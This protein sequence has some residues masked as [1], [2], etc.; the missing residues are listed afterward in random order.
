MC[1][2]TQRSM[3]QREPKR[4]IDP[5]APGPARRPAGSAAPRRRSSN[6]R[7]TI[8]SLIGREIRR[9][10]AI[11]SLRPPPILCAR[12]RQAYCRLCV[13]LLAI[14]QIP[15]NVAAPESFPLDCFA[16]GYRAGFARF[17]GRRQN[18]HRHFLRH[19][20]PLGRECWRSPAKGRQLCG[21]QGFNTPTPIGSKSATFLVTTVKP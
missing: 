8:T 17:Y 6:R 3:A 12:N 18:N 20:F 4:A 9:A 10:R 15:A 1:A 2:P 7:D 21:A 19:A 5:R 11:T 16:E 14:P 13:T